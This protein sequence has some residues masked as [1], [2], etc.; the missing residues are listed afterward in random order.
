M[1]NLC[2]TL[3]F[4][5]ILVASTSSYS[6]SIYQNGYE[7]LMID[8]KARK[9]GDL[10]TVMIYESASAA[11]SANTNS[12]KS[13]GVSGNLESDR[14]SKF[15]ELN[16][17]NSTAGS[18]TIS[19]TGKLVASVSVTV[20]S[21]TEYGDLIVSGH[22]KIEFNDETQHINIKGRV[23]TEDIQP[24]NSILSTRL[25]DAEIVFVGDGLLGERQKPGIITRVFNWLF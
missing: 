17:D 13:I 7:P 6:E 10:I 16:L 20:D 4:L 23:R 9:V 12:S 25:A 14:T 22:Q 21:I 15:A 19:R 1:V 8:H 11:A 18:G 5:V 2:K 3:T 24:D